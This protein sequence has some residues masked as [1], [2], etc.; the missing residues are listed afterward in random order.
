MLFFLNLKESK[1]IN[2]YKA[3]KFKINKMKML[4][5]LDIFSPEIKLRILNGNTNFKTVKGGLLS[6]LCFLLILASFFF[7][8]DKFFKRTESYIMINEIFTNIVTLENFSQYPFMLRVSNSNSAV[9]K[10]ADKYMDFKL[11]Y[12]W[13]EKNL[14]DN[15][16]IQKKEFIEMEPCNINNSV[17]FNLKYKHLFENYDDLDTF[18]CPNYK[19][20]Y[21]VYGL[22]GDVQPF[23]Y[24]Q[25]YF[26]SCRNETESNGKCGDK[27]F[28]QKYFSNAYLDFR[29]VTYEIIQLM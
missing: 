28:I 16:V 17:H 4:K 2:F 1:K 12:W 26:R 13:S 6:L 24:Y 8:L 21:S 25:F 23:S 14:T 22:Y 29:T 19:R 7:F 11:A 20:E 18:F 9:L 3:Q 5:S 15:T 27:A 10:P